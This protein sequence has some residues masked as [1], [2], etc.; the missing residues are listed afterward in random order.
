M[1]G[2][3][4]GRKG[5]EQVDAPSLDRRQEQDREQDRVRWPEDRRTGRRKPGAQANLRTEIV[6]RRDKERDER[7]SEQRPDDPLAVRAPGERS[8][9]T[10]I[11]RLQRHYFAEVGA[12]LTHS[13][14]RADRDIHT[15]WLAQDN[16]QEGPGPR[17]PLEWTRARYCTILLA[18]EES[19]PCKDQPN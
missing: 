2:Q 9:A 1:L 15:T 6:R 11:A 12:T 10:L 4:V 17:F 5:R 16:P 19:M 8:R 3:K 7:G 14:Y 18:P 13:S